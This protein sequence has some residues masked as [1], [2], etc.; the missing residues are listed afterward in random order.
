MGIA[1]L[2]L[3]EVCAAVTVTIDTRTIVDRN[4]HAPLVNSKTSKTMRPL[5][6]H[7]PEGEL[8]D[9]SPENTT[10]TP[11]T[12]APAQSAHSV[13]PHFDPASRPDVGLLP[14]DVR[15][16]L[17]GFDLVVLAL[18][19]FVGGAVIALIVATA[20]I[21]IFGIPRNAFQIPSAARSTL[22]VLSQVLLSGAMLALLFGMVRSRGTDDFWPS[23]GWRRLPGH[24][25]RSATIARYAFFGL[26]LAASVGWLSSYFDRN[27]PLPME[28]LFHDRQSVLLLTGL[29]VLVAPFFEETL[30]RG[31]IY[32][33]LARRWGVGVSVVTTG[34]LFG[35]AHAPQLWPGYAQIALLMFVGIVLT[36][37][38][39][40]TGTVAAGYFVHVG[41]NSTLFGLLYFATGGLRHFPS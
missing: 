2:C 32:P 18:F 3:R 30:F 9:Q 14:P 35:A 26:L 40:R 38:R 11:A 12:I 19:Y 37:I 34:I 10:R 33:V 29:G 41:Y 31:C 23:L 5:D 24:A 4:G 6:G 25:S 7:F 15:T 36:Y 22:I 8:A 1:A 21:H 27:V 20:A 17:N 39:A 13:S 28:E 16:P